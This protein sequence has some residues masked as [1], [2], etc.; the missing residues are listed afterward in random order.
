MKKSITTLI[1]ALAISTSYG[2]TRD[3]YLWPFEAKSIWNLPL[4]NDA[5]SGSN[6]EDANIDVIGTPEKFKGEGVQMFIE[7][8]SDPL[9]EYHRVFWSDRCTGNDYHYENNYVHF[10]DDYTWKGRDHGQAN[11]AWG[12]LKADGE[13]IWDGTLFTRCSPGSWVGGAWF[14][15]AK[16]YS[17]LGDG[18]GDVIS[19]PD[20]FSQ[21]DVWGHG[22]SRI[23]AF[24]GVIRKGELTSPESEPIRHA[25]KFTIQASKYLASCDVYGGRPFKWPAQGSDGYAC[26]SNSDNMYGGSNA[27]F[28]MGSLLALPPGLTKEDLGLTSIQARKIFDALQTYGGYVVED[29]GRGDRWQFFLEEEAIATDW[30]TGDHSTISSG[31]F[32]DE[33]TSIVANLHIVKLNNPNNIGGG[34]TSDLV[35]RVGPIACPLGTVGSGETCT[36]GGSDTTP[37][38]APSGLN[39]TSGDQQVSLDWND[40]SESDLNGYNVYR[41][42]TSGS[43]YSKINTALVSNSDYTDNSVSNG[44][45]Y[46]YVVTAEDNS[47]NESGNSAESSA[48]PSGSGQGSELTFNPTDDGSINPGF[49]GAT[50]RIE[51]GNNNRI[52]YFKFN[53]SGTGGS[54]V[55]TAT[56]KLYCNGDDG[57]G[58]I[59]VYTGSHNNWSE[60]NT[61]NLPST[62]SLLGEISGNYNIGTWYSWD[63][64]TSAFSGDGT[65]TLIVKHESTGSDAWFD[66]REAGN[67]PELIL[68]VSQGGSTT[69]YLEDFNDNNAQNWVIN[70]GTWNAQNQQ[71]EQSSTSNPDM[72][73]YYDEVSFTDYILSADARPDWGN[74][75]G[76]IFNYQ[77]ANNYYLLWLDAKPKIT[78]IKKIE[79]GNSLTI[80]SSNYS[81]GGVDQWYTLTVENSNNSTTASINGSVVF[82]NISTTAFGS[83]KIGL[84]ANYCPSQF[85]NISVVDGSNQ[86][87]G[88]IAKD[89]SKIAPK[90]VE[91]DVILYP[92]PVK[93]I[94][95]I[96]HIAVSDNIEVMD[97]SGKIVL[98]DLQINANTAEI[99]VS[100]LPKGVYLLKLKGRE[101]NKVIRFIKQ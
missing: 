20:D 31:S 26:D 39:T 11:S 98:A 89:D 18:A 36:N 35:N 40:N 97:L 83:G 67:Q 10:P 30:P 46:Y 24:G 79:N 74:Q 69:N 21:V 81:G 3:P 93:D 60:S 94:L 4:H 34:P 33:L 73:A 57:N 15:P 28:V 63:L 85:D 19:D 65:Y 8:D 72:I 44:T 2:Q 27:D 50:V 53:V 5:W 42:T 45:T 66:S 64:S 1:V 13:T 61:S 82:N 49:T 80:A 87:R 100:H 51:N 23:S 29:A 12:M 58:T 25:L 54:S 70:T 14:G 68:N 91:S 84:Y 37:P 9:R 17:I 6:S 76:L 7:D 71:Y 52:G 88:E 75:F 22:A 16:P 99:D 38:S 48:T 96:D 62:S 95:K 86:R 77:D 78:E 56:L 32:Y 41:S 55:N 59:R 90:L 92:N 101:N 43:G 47:A